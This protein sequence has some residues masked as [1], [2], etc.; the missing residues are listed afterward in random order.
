MRLRKFPRPE[1]RHFTISHRCWAAR[2]WNNNEG[3]VS[4]RDPAGF[5][6]GF[7]SIR[8]RDNGT[9]GGC[10]RATVLFQL[11]ASVCLIFFFT[12]ICNALY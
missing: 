7:E 3:R 8:P 6:I 12:G 10:F 11:L 1:L 5:P 9:R 2:G 4:I